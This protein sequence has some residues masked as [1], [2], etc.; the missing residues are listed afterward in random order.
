MQRELTLQVCVFVVFVENLLIFLLY[1]IRFV[2]WSCLFLFVS[3][4]ASSAPGSTPRE[5][6]KEAPVREAESG[7]GAETEEPDLSTLSLTEKMSLFNRL[8]QPATQQVEGTRADSRLRR[9]NTRFQ[10]QPITQGEVE[11]VSVDTL[12]IVR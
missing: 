11:Q 1:I 8:S 10:T 12:L 6:E 3:L 9:G 4:Q 7:Q 2:M 5:Q